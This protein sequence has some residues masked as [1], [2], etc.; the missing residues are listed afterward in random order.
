[1]RKKNFKGRCVKRSLSKCVGVC[2]TYDDIQY[3]YADVLQETEGVKEFRCNVLMEGLELGE[4]M[5]DFVI[6]TESDETIVR[7]CV[8]RSHLTKPMTVKLYV[9]CE[10]CDRII[11]IDDAI[12]S[13]NN[14]CYYCEDCYDEYDT[15]YIEE[16][17][18]K[19]Y[20]EFYGESKDGLYLGVELEVTC[21]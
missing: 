19:P 5:S 13:E 8:Q 21:F 4:Y 16:Y 15:S 18:Y 10:E 12:R 14:D 1:M 9:I 6:V 20:P 2:R 11:D 7:E 17:G 3:A